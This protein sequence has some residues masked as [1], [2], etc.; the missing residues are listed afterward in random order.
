[1]RSGVAS[2]LP[3]CPRDLAI[4]I[5]SRSGCRSHE[6]GKLTSNTNT[7]EANSPGLWVTRPADN[8]KYR[9]GRSHIQYE[10]GRSYRRASGPS[11]SQQLLTQQFARDCDLGSAS[12]SLTFES[13]FSPQRHALF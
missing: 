2:Q 3:E 10:S 9:S 4:G 12:H 7:P 5:H 6:V 1:M 13:T 11:N 8:P